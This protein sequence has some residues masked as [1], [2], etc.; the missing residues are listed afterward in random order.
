MADFEVQYD[1][2]KF[3]VSTKFLDP[4]SISKKKHYDEN[5]IFMIIKLYKEG[6]FKS[7]SKD[8]KQIH[9]TSVSSSDV[10]DMF[11]EQEEEEDDKPSVKCRATTKAGSQCSK[12]SSGV[13]GLCTMHRKM[14]Q[15]GK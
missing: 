3:V 4:T 7:T 13:D 1:K 15:Q 14:I 10:S 11:I 8:C 5:E 2:K 9:L 6:A 12:N